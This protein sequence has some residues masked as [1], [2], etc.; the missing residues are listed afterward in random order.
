MDDQSL[1]FHRTVY[2]AYHAL[3][4][5]EP[6]RVKVVDGRTDID[7]LERSVWSVVSAYV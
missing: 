4:E 1:D 6:C 3:A 7:T 5:A 2:R